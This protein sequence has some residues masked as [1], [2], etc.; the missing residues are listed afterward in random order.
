MPDLIQM[1]KENEQLDILDLLSLISTMLSLANYGQNLNQTKAAE[2]LKD[3]V[4][5]VHEH[6]R[7]QDEKIKRILEA[8][9]EKDQRNH[10]EDG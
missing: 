4:E 3:A 1:N 6:L 5:D 7:R 10:H 2:L 8:L 9:D